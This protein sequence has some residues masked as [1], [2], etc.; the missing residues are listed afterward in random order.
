MCSY[1]TEHHAFPPASDAEMLRHL[2]DAKAVTQTQLSSESGLPKSSV[3]EV[4]SGK[5][6][7]G[8]K[9]IHALANYFELDVGVLAANI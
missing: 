9:M 5:K 4:L 3:S 8:R 7:F 6:P 2:M 1:E